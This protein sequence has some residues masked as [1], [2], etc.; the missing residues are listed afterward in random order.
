MTVPEPDEMAF[1]SWIDSSG[2]LNSALA[3][4]AWN[5]GILHMHDKIITY[6]AA[7]SAADNA[8][9][10]TVMIA[11]AEEIQAHWDAHCDAEGYGPANLMRR[12]EE[13]IPS[14]YGYTAGRFA[15]LETGNKALREALE[16]IAKSDSG[17]CGCYY[18]NRTNIS[19]ARAALKEKRHG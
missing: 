3:R 5:A 1:E 13:G 6:A 11:A 10:R 8:S 4:Q 19:I 7:V 9:L 16:K 14:Q 15:E 12:L 17:E 18:T 2:Y